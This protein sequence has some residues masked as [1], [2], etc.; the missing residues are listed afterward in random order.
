MKTKKYEFTTKSRLG[1][2]IKVAIRLEKENDFDIDEYFIV[3]EKSYR[4]YLQAE[5]FINS[6]IGQSF[7]E[8]ANK[9]RE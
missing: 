1:N 8:L 6:P 3:F 5:S 4:T 7:L 9:T 2:E